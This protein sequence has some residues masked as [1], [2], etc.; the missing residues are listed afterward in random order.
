MMNPLEITAVLLGAAALLP[1]ALTLFN[2]AVW[3]RGQPD[4]AM[5]G[6]VSVLI[7]ARNEASNIGACLAAAQASEHP[8][9]EIL[10]YDDASTDDTASI[11]E[12]F[13]RTDPRIRVI[14]GA[15]L[16]RGWAG[17]SHA[18]HRLALAAKGDVLLFID[19]DVRLEPEGIRRLGSQY[20]ALDADLVSALPRQDTLTWAE[21]LILPLL[22]VTY[23]S[24]LPLP[25]IHRNRDSRFLA[26][27]G[28]ILS[29]RSD[30]FRSVGG[31][32][33]V[34]ND[35]VEDMAFCRLV[36]K[37]GFRV[38]FLDGHFIARCRMYTNAQ[39][40]WEGFS[41]NLYRGVGANMGSLLGVFALYL[42]CF[43]VPYAIVV[44]VAAS[45]AI[46]VPLGNGF[47]PLLWAAVVGVAANTALRTV[48][49]LRYHQSLW[50][51]VT[52]PVAVLVLVAIG[53]NSF[54]W[55]RR[56]AIR[57]RGRIYGGQ[58]ELTTTAPPAH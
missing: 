51:V 15:D 52:H 46:G 20:E 25:L 58:S 36:K 41:K 48:I 29:I 7:P 21:R 37:R 32:A 42:T 2:A 55:H 50:G 8:L 6:S 19:A 28:Q 44:G 17:K 49:A 16:P 43:V 23:T 56:G 40:V 11:A 18:C 47:E 13:A 27:N 45:T 12:S 24:W 10:V 26:V 14:R 39:E 54:V 53:I 3:R 4:G 30:V 5:P 1:L 9:L 57:W 38:A 33:A 34:K 35:V 31:F 22:Y